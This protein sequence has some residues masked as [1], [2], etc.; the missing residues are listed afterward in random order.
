MSDTPR[1]AMI[2]AAGFGTRMRPL[3]DHTPK[4]LLRVAGKP[5]L[6]HAAD[7]ALALG[8]SPIVVNAHYL[9]DQVASAVA[10]RPGLTLQDET[11]HILDTGGGLKAAL[12]VLGVGPVFTMNSDAVWTGPNPYYRLAEAWR[13]EKMD[14]LLMV[15]PA[16]RAVA[17]QGSGSFTLTPQGRLTLGGPQVYTG[18]QIIKTDALRD[19]GEAVFSMHRLWEPALRAGRMF[20]LEHSGGWCDVGHPGGIELAEAMANV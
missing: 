15:I 7:P 20:G 17:H 19:I 18:L 9:A 2:F 8:L 11:P 10:T 16:A 1:A 5:L 14:A 6:D 12:P 4:P 13:P 3:T